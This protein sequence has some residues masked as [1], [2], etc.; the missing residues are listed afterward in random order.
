MTTVAFP[1]IHDSIPF[2]SKK[3]YLFSDD[4]EQEHLTE[5]QLQLPYMRVPG[6]QKIKRNEIVVFNQPA[7]T[8]LDMNNFHPDRNYY[9]PIDK[10]TN[11]VSAAWESQVIVLKYV[12]GMCLSTDKKMY[13][14]IG[15]NFSF[16]II[17]IQRKGF[18]QKIKA[19]HRERI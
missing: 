12:M 11:L 17:S 5:K 14:P 8:L 3:S 18:Q 4:Y 19:I 7:D 1:M 2:T 16:I 13:S 6:F 10:K 9:K 15:Q